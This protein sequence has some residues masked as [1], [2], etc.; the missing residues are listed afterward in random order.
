MTRAEEQVQQA[1]RA[2]LATLTEQQL[3]IAYRL[4]DGKTLKHISRELN[5]APNTVANH[6]IRIYRRLGVHSRYQFVLMLRRPFVEEL[7]VEQRDGV[8]VTGSNCRMVTLEAL[9]RWYRLACYAE[10]ARVQGSSE[11]TLE[12]QTMLGSATP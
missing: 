10:Q 3:Q 1:A 11:L 9:R 7:Q 12:L 4:A 6:C 5:I 8:G 2:I